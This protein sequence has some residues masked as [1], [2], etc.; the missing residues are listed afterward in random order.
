MI[1]RN[2]P[3]GQRRQDDDLLRRPRF[4]GSTRRTTGFN[5]PFARPVMEQVSPETASE[6]G[7]EFAKKRLA[8]AYIPNQ[9]WKNLL[10][11]ESALMNG[12][13]FR[14]LVFPFEGRTIRRR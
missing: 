8:M 10:S 4:G 12:T 7:G 6:N 2:N 14:E 9:T 5:E 11:P 1:E 3:S 13:I